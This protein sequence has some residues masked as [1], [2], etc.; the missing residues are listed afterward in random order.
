MT[1]KRRD[2]RGGSAG[3]GQRRALLR[4]KALWVTLG[5]MAL[6]AVLLLAS[7]LKCG[8]ESRG[9]PLRIGRTVEGRLEAGDWTDVFADGS[10]TDLYVIQLE[11]G[12]R[13]RAELSS[14]E[15]DTYLSLMRGPGDQVADND[16]IST[17]DRNSRIVYTSPAREQLY[18]AVTTFQ[19]GAT[20]A[21]TL[22][23][24]DEAEPASGSGEKAPPGADAG[25]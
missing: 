22:R 16:D 1:R 13:I 7:S 5:L 12:Q 4:S 24:V 3:K 19:S 2:K 23:V 17:T 25:R 18:L 10:Y 21:Y 9:A 20:G 14:D 11:A 6:A 8:G 15:F